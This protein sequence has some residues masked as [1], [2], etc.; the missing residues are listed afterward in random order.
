MLAHMKRIL[1]AVLICG[2]FSLP[3]LADSLSGPAGLFIYVG[4]SI[5]LLGDVD[6]TDKIAG[7]CLLYNAS[8]EMWEVAVCSGTG[9]GASALEVA[10]GG[11]Q[12]SSPTASI[13]FFMLPR[14]L[15]STPAICSPTCLIPKA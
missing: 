12:I 14:L 4:D 11:V 1:A 15:T 10:L 7:S 5:N 3:V 9:S 2:L 6:T 13:N 8:T